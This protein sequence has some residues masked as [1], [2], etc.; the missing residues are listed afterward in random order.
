MSKPLNISNKD[1]LVYANNLNSTSNSNMTFTARDGSGVLT[2][3]D[4]ALGL[5]YGISNERP[6]L[7]TI[8]MIR[9]NT[10]TSQLEY[11]NGTIWIGLANTQPQIID[12]SPLS[13]PI[14]DASVIITGNT[15]GTSVPSVSFIGQDSVIRNAASVSLLTPNSVVKAVLPTSV[16]DNSNQEPFAIR[17]TNNDYGVFTTTAPPLVIDINSPPF[18]VSSSD[19]G[20][21]SNNTLV[22]SLVIT[23]QLDI[24]ALDTEN[25]TITFSSSNLNSATGLNI[26]PVNGDISGTLTN[27]GADTTYNFD[28]TIT[29]SVG[30]V[31]TS[32]FFFDFVVPKA[33]SLSLTSSTNVTSSVTYLDSGYSLVGGP[34]IG[35]FTIYKLTCTSGASN[36]TVTVEPIITSGAVST[37]FTDVSYVLVAG[38]GGGGANVGGGGGAGGVLLGTLPTLTSTNALVIG[39]YGAG[40]PGSNGGGTTETAGSSGNNSTGFSLTAL[41]GGGGGAGLYS[42]T[43]GGSAANGGSGGGEGVINDPSGPGSG[44]SPQGN[45]GGQ[46]FGSFPGGAGGGGGYSSVGANSV[47]NTGGNGG[48]ALD[49]SAF[50]GT[51]PSTSTVVAGGGGGGGNSNASAPGGSGGAASAITVGGQGGTLTGV[52]GA[53]S[54]AVVDTGSGGGGGSANY[55]TGGNGSSGVIFIRF[56]SY[57]ETLS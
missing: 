5:P 7:P 39:A 22:S 52:S 13:V 17:L 40:G 57:F 11:Y 8:G 43:P 48:G 30:N 33:V 37:T 19:L 18:F 45:N 56:P 29:D 12:I 4:S 23:N 25:N 15:F 32:P 16:I 35:G 1:W 10:D 6:L 49:L 53:G 55:W 46:S 9:Y 50:L 47:G 51:T 3:V 28:I 21:V 44:T 20:E 31:K 38:G 42:G 14:V 26:D 41:G 34:V 54:A 2:L 27:P 24:S 36:G